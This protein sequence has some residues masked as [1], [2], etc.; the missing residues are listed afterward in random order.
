MAIHKEAFAD[1]EIHLLKCFLL[2]IIVTLET[3]RMTLHDDFA[4]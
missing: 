2:L 4:L 3:F 1:G